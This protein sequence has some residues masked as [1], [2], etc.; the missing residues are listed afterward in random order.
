[1]AHDTELAERLRALLA[2]HDDLTEKRMFGGQAF[3][4]GGHMAVCASSRGVLMVRIDPARAAA[5]LERPG[6]SP[7]E[8]N[9]RRLTGWLDVEGELDDAALRGWVDEGVAY[10]RSLPPKGPPK[11]PPKEPP[12]GP[13]K[14]RAR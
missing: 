2:A 4:L 5:L 10:V 1:M 14:A 8:M 7:M 11:E 12:K 9:G 3:L 13:P 6:A